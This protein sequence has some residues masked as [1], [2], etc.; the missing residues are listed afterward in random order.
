MEIKAKLSYF[1]YISLLFMFLLV[2]HFDSGSI[3]SQRY[4]LRQKKA[5]ILDKA[6]NIYWISELNWLIGQLK[7]DSKGYKWDSRAR[8]KN[9][10]KNEL[11]KKREE[12]TRWSWAYP[13]LSNLILVTKY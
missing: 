3:G 10:E 6:S 9:G 2:F 1:F 11:R 8:S 12:E 7:Q 4:L 5:N 13:V